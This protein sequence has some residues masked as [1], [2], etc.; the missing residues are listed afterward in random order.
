[1]K[2]QLGKRNLNADARE[3]AV[4][5][6]QRSL[7]ATSAL[8]YWDQ[9]TC[10]HY[11]KRFGITDHFRYAAAT[12]TDYWTWAGAPFAATSATTLEDSLLK[13]QIAAG[14]RSFLFYNTN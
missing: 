6:R 8:D 1:M 5:M 13:V 12:L 4:V 2:T 9:L 7:R 3:L 10:F 11:G 14:A